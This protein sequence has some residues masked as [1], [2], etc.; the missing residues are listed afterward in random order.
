[1][2]GKL[3][4]SEQ[5]IRVELPWPANPL[6]PNARPHRMEKARATKKAREEACMVARP[7]VRGLTADRLRV[8]ITFRPPSRRGDA[9]N[10]LAAC[11]AYLDGI[12]DATGVNDRCFD[13]DM[14]VR[15]EPVKGGAIIIEMV[16]A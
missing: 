7:K 12:A 4:P 14:P 2:S 6:H 5:M 11:K 16:P 10:M 15:G 8:A 9:D 3:S 13:I 1:M